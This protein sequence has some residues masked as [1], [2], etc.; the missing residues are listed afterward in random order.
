MSLT[1][2]NLASFVATAEALAEIRDRRLYRDQFPTFDAYC[3]SHCGVSG[4]RVNQLIGIAEQYA[5]RGQS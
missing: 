2:E 5:A 3:R 1:P 4:Q